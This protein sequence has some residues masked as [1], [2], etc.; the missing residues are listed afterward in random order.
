VIPYVCCQDDV[1]KNA[2]RDGAVAFNGIDFLEVV[3]DGTQLNLRVHF[4]KP[5]GISL[6]KRNVRIE[7]GERVI[8]P[9]ADTTSVSGKEFTVRVVEPGDFTP[10]T[11]RLVEGTLSDKPPNGIDPLL[12]AVRFTFKVNCPS[13]FDCKVVRVCPPAA[14]ESPQI[15]YLAKDY[16]S[17]RQLMLDRLDVLTP[18][19]HSREAADLGMVL[20][21]LLAYVGDQL[22][23]FQDAVAT[24]AYLATARRRVSVRRHARLV[25]YRM[26]DG[27]NARAW[28][29]VQLPQD[30]L[31]SPDAGVVVPRGTR[32]LTA[33][34]GLPPVLDESAY[35]LALGARP[36]VFETLDEVRV[37]GGNQDL[38]LY[39]WGERECCLP[40]GST[41]ATLL[42]RP[43]LAEG[44]V[45]VLAERLG[46]ET[47]STADADPAHRQAVRLTAVRP[48][49]DEIGGR[50]EHPPTGDPVDV[51]D[52]EWH[53]DD[54]LRFPLCIS[55]E[56]DRGYRADVGHARG[57]I[58][59]ADHGRTVKA[60]E[61]LPEERVEHL[62]VV[63]EPV[64]FRPPQGDRCEDR[65]RA[66]VAP[67]F[68]P[69]PAES[70]LTQAAPYDHADPPA[71]ATAAMTW[72]T[73]D[74]MPSIR[75]YATPPGA[76]HPLEWA[77]E[78]DLLEAGQTTRAFVVEVE[79]DGRALIRFGDDIFGLR[80]TSGTSFDAVYRVGNGTAGNVGAGALAHIVIDG[81]SPITGVTN[82]LP[83]SGGV[84]RE[85]AERA[86]QN[87]PSAFR[88]QQRAVTLADY[89]EITERHAGIQRAAGS[90]RWTGSW[91]TVFVTVDRLDGRRLDGPFRAELSRYLDGYRMAG[92]DVDV[93]GPQFAS[94][95]IE[96]HVCV[97]HDYFRSDVEQ[98]LRSVFSSG[99]LPDGRRGFFHP[100][101]F[102]FGQPVWLSAVYA[103]AQAVPGVESLEVTKFQRQGND[104]SDARDSGVLRLSRL[105]IA[106]LEQ[107]PDFP[108]H[109]KLTIE[110][111]GGK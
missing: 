4:L 23:Y 88:T 15:D 83:A 93:D 21:E 36:E 73:D 1:R 67:R 30:D 98:Q 53:V 91:P 92:Q 105:E 34:P 49:T 48:G 37:H 103:A 29:Q 56:T 22:S 60:E 17:F 89:A 51:T 100:D 107:N 99:T 31:V 75:L 8:D 9:A 47:G 97:K 28:V 74:A 13:D 39:T 25:D 42:G 46:P 84:E 109:G 76:E 77:P 104:A 12:A 59:L 38:S 101:N 79:S 5:I 26:H 106:R 61:R 78:R 80:P 66:P 16:S 110:L 68:R 27:C 19:W 11:L 24:E 33:V 96:L 95:D 81:P 52:I 3:D 2:V 71:S 6:D 57:N 43:Q 86:R 54:A 102:T 58:V 111:G 14:V 55:S 90:V 20:V 35:R 87:A 18:R 10:Y 72:R 85:D 70:P 82:P 41:T 44:D 50:F 40:V 108:E 65:V 7:G 62:G 63:P 94:L 45:L 32:L 64:L 69:S